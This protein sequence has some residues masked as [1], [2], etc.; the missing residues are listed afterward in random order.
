M[1]YQQCLG[2]VAPIVLGFTGVLQGAE[3][4]GNQLGVEAFAEGCFTQAFLPA[5][6][7]VQIESVKSPGG[8]GNIAGQLAETLVQK[9]QAHRGSF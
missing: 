7:E 3:R 9:G 1:G 8:T 2:F 5:A 4:V 6:T